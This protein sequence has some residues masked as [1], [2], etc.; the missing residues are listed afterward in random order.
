V[1]LPGKGGVRIEDV[2]VVT[3][4]TG[5]RALTSLAQPSTTMFSANSEL[6]VL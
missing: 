6:L 2:L 4:G 1:Y 5:A 3:A